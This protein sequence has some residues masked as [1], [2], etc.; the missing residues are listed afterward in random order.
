MTIPSALTL[1]VGI[2]PEPHEQAQAIGAFGGSGGVG[3]GTLS[4]PWAYF[5]YQLAFHSVLG[6]LIGAIFVKLASWRWIFW[7]ITIIAFPI[8]ILSMVFIPPPH[9]AD[10][11]SQPTIIQK[12]NSLDLGG[13]SLLTGISSK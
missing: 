9:S 8:A 13:I 3:N 12:L 6:L 7:F 5:T 1:L 10:R 2:F 4:G 11:S